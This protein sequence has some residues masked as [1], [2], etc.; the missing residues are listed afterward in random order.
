M[1]CTISVFQPVLPYH[2]DTASRLSD[3]ITTVW[4]L[5]ISRILRFR[6]EPLTRRQFIDYVLPMGI[7]IALETG[8]SNIVLKLLTMSFG[9]IL[10]GGAHIFTMF[11][12]LLFR[13]ETFSVN[14][15]AL[16]TLVALR[17]LRSAKGIRF[18][19][20]GL[21]YNCWPQHWV[22]YFGLCHMCY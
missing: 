21:F 4:A 18:H 5:L 20:L 1:C 9:T 17:W 7:T 16:L 2:H 8:S 14:L 10:K 13:V 6:P 22:G 11:W 3:S 15:L 19:I 12:R